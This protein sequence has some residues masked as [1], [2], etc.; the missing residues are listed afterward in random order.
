[1]SET[2]VLEQ[3]EVV[4]IVA[5]KQRCLGNLALVE[6]ILKKFTTQL[7]CD[8]AELEKAARIGDAESFALVAHRIKGMSANVEA[9]ELNRLAAT[10]EQCALARVISELPQCL[11][12]LKLE[13]GRIAEVLPDMQIEL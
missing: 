5:L 8:L 3:A 1:M 6:R 7:N 2:A 9:R 12:R 10:A 13:R 4:D 11:E